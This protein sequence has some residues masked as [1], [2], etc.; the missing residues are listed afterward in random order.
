[1]T[2]FSLFSK[3]KLKKQKFCLEA[4]ELLQ[5]CIY[6]SYVILFKKT[7]PFIFKLK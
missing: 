1:M 2:V 3:T 4:I 6:T 7:L 5:T